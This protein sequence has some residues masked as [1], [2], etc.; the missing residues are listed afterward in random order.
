MARQ[1][2]ET[3][4]LRYCF[5]DCSFDFVTHDTA[6]EMFIEIS[7]TYCFADCDGSAAVHGIFY[8]GKKV[9]YVGWRPD[10]HYEFRFVENHELAWEGWFPNWEH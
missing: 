7:K 4:Y 8:H 6:D 2:F 3:G 1:T 9:E 10:M 5:D